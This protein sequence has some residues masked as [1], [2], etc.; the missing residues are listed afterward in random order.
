MT[1]RK[2]GPDFEFPT[3][4]K[5]PRTSKDGMFEVIRGTS[6]PLKSVSI[7]P[8]V[9][10]DDSMWELREG[11]AR[12]CLAGQSLSSLPVEIL[13]N[14]F[15]YFVPASFKI[16]PRASLY[17]RTGAR[18]NAFF[19]SRATLLNL[20]RVSKQMRRFAL[21]LLYRNVFLS[22]PG[23]L[24]DFLYITLA[25]KEPR[26]ADQLRNLCCAM[27]L[28]NPE[29]AFNMLAYCQ[30][31]PRKFL[32]GQ[33]GIGPDIFLSMSF[34]MYIQYSLYNRWFA[35]N[36]LFLLLCAARELRTLQCRLPE[37]TMGRPR[38]AMWNWFLNGK[39]IDILERTIIPNTTDP[40]PEGYRGPRHCF[41]N[42]F[43]RLVR[44]ELGGDLND[45]AGGLSFIGLDLV[46]PYDA[47]LHLRMRQRSGLEDPVDLIR[48][49][50]S[51]AHLGAR[52]HAAFNTY[53]DSLKRLKTVQRWDSKWNLDVNNL[54]DSLKTFGSPG[55]LSPDQHRR[56]VRCLDTIPPDW[57][58]RPQAYDKELFF[59]LS[60]FVGLHLDHQPT[61]E[62]KI[63][64]NNITSIV[65]HTLIDGDLPPWRFMD[66]LEDRL[67]PFAATVERLDLP[68]FTV[69]DV[70]IRIYRPTGRLTCVREFRRLR[71]LGIT[72]EGFFG[73]WCRT[74]AAIRCFRVSDPS[75]LEATVNQLP[76]NL[77]KLKLYEW[78][79]EFSIES[80]LVNDVNRWQAARLRQE[81]WLAG[82][83]YMGKLLRA[84]CHRL[85]E[86]HVQLKYAFVLDK[87][88]PE[89]H[90]E[91]SLVETLLG[92]FAKVGIKITVNRARG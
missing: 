12:L 2:A 17:Q 88:L 47:V 43:L 59:R 42:P 31:L 1:K 24:I 37:P 20:S 25:S 26:P 78:Y 80:F 54:L 73:S 86:V 84:R 39:P 6:T 5:V 50:S 67:L 9:P 83:N 61:L 81:L 15:E 82:L 62:D 8:W 58:D 55:E 28:D 76:E 19:E 22:R 75:R 16:G 69:P 41:P 49:P 56:F 40:I 23:S 65:L 74:E 68:L 21:P 92:D 53:L 51:I 18:W 52:E 46:R 89:K 71:E 27:P 32:E 34:R 77:T 63:S 44:F 60:K 90:G 4:T 45:E 79:G 3:C 70:T 7:A 48:R 38:P 11:F 10:R 33:V 13:Q 29:M 30:R 14:I 64:R 66:P 72:L 91:N 35:Q 85:T 57:G 36:M 87:Y